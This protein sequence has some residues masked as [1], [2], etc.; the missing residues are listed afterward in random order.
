MF[1]LP[2]EPWTQNLALK[3]SQVCIPCQLTGLFTHCII[4]R[5][6]GKESNPT[7]FSSYIREAKIYDESMVAR[8]KVSMDGI[9][10]YAAL[11]SAVVTAFIIESYKTLSHDSGDVMIL[12]LLQMFQQLAALGND[13]QSVTIIESL[14]QISTFRPS[15]AVV[16]TNAFWFLSLS[17]SL[18]CALIATLIQQWASDY[19]HAIEC[20]QAPERRAR[21]RAFLFEGVEN[22]NVSA[23]VDGTPVLLHISLFSFL[24]GL[25]VFM[26]PINSIIT[27]LLVT[28]LIGCGSAY[29][30][31]TVLPLVTI[32]SPIR[33]PVT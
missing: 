9:V 23:I 29:S 18:A 17:L 14:D 30:W 10:I 33:T 6:H 27:Y 16:I 20:R 32:S 2:S 21:I 5:N 4:D 8:W 7:V 1:I 11:F 25:V 19:I 22:S 26:Q 24:M 15:R 28:I 13:S 31:S 3:L 12:L